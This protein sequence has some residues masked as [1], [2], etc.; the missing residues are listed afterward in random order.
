M[1]GMP[2]TIG[3]SLLQ[4]GQISLPENICVYIKWVLHQIECG[5]IF[6]KIINFVNARL[7][8]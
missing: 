8:L 5:A 3:Y 7:G 6:S 1:F 4:L 2:L